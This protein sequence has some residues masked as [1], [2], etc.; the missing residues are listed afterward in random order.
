MKISSISFYSSKQ[1]GKS[2]ADIQCIKIIKIRYCLIFLKNIGNI[3]T[4]LKK[5][6]DSKRKKR[7]IQ[8]LSEKWLEVMDTNYIKE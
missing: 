7:G 8:L 6:F 4:A 3:E 2:I 1:L 5:S